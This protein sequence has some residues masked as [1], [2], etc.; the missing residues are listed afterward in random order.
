MRPAAGLLDDAGVDDYLVKVHDVDHAADIRPDPALATMLAKVLPR[1]WV[2]TASTV[3]HA[4]KCMEC[5]GIADLF[6]GIVD[7]RTCKL[8]SKYSEVWCTCT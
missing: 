1:R 4:T 3:V 8:E 5:V 2:F 7:T 6:E